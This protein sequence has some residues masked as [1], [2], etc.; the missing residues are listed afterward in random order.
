MH[1]QIPRAFA[2]REPGGAVAGVNARGSEGEPRG[3]DRENEV[4]FVERHSSRGPGVERLNP[5]HDRLPG[6]T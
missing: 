5:I 3:R 2:M 1:C 4:L 6:A